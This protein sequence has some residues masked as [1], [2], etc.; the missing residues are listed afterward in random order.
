MKRLYRKFR[1]KAMDHSRAI[2]R[3]LFTEGYAWATGGKIV[4]YEDMPFLFSNSEDMS[5]TFAREEDYFVANEAEEYV[6]IFGK[7][8]PVTEGVIP[9]LGLRPRVIA[10]EHRIQ[11]LTEAMG[12]FMEKR[13]PL[14]LEWLEEYTDLIEQHKKFSQ[15]A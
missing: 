14:P 15:A 4:Q 11:E 2:Q 3:A 8:R 9:A 1:V 6:F 13:M 7:L 12:R 5:V 10:I